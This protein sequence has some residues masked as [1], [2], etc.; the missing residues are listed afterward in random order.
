M[1]LVPFPITSRGEYGSDASED[2]LAGEFLAPS[3]TAVV[4]VVFVCS[5]G[6]CLITAV[7]CPLEHI[8]IIFVLMC[9]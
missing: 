7:F 9:Y 3:M 1:N 8:F 2:L 4:L 5:F 6:G